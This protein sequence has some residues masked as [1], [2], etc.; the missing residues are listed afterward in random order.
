MCR[1]PIARGFGLEASRPA[2]VDDIVAAVKGG[3]KSMTPLFLDVWVPAEHELLP[4]VAP[5]VAAAQ[6]D[7][8]RPIY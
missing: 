4:P 7:V 8:N 3:M 6:G 1:A 2:N 5:W